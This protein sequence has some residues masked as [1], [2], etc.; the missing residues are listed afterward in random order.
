MYKNN[1]QDLDCERNVLFKTT[2]QCQ[3]QDDPS[4]SQVDVL[5]KNKIHDYAV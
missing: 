2:L 5:Q 4:V 1:Y 3:S